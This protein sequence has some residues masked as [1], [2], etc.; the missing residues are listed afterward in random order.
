MQTTKETSNYETEKTDEQKE[1]YRWSPDPESY[2]LFN[3]IMENTSLK[4]RFL[5]S[6]N[7]DRTTV[8]TELS[9]LEYRELKQNSDS[10]TYDVLKLEYFD[11][12]NDRKEDYV[13][14]ARVIQGS[15]TRLYLT[16]NHA[17][18]NIGTELNPKVL[19]PVAESLGEERKNL[20]DLLER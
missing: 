11:L 15:N 16:Y 14:S 4:D 20:I 5:V 19:D 18:E 6:R 10:E 17:A 7:Q 8:E 3:D 2:A 1:D 13:I 9:P 12:P